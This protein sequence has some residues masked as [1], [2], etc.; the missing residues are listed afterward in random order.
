L[1]DAQLRAILISRIESS[2]VYNPYNGQA[3]QLVD[4][5]IAHL[6]EFQLPSLGITEEIM[7]DVLSRPDIGD[8][9]NGLV[10]EVWN[11]PGATPFRQLNY[12]LIQGTQGQ[13]V[14][15]QQHALHNFF[16]RNENASVWYSDDGMD[17]VIAAINR[18]SFLYP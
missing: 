13:L 12:R 16:S 11:D 4:S 18:D 15:N 14:D 7:R 8:R 1:T 2:S 3:I 5:L 10:R 17:G 9:I 6:D